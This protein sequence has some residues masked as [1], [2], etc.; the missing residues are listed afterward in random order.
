MHKN[1]EISE[2]YIK[3]IYATICTLVI[4]K[5]QNLNQNTN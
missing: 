5:I 3:T 4:I 1:K 2:F